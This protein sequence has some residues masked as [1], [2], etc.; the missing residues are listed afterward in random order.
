MTRVL[1]LANVRLPTEKA[2]GLQIMQNCEAFAECGAD[3]TLWAARRVNTPELRGR[4]PFAHYGVERRFRLRRLP[5]LDLLPFVPGQTG[6]LAKVCFAVQMLTYIVSAW[7]GLLFARADVLYSRDAY[8]LLITAPLARL[9]RMRIG[10]EAHTRAGSRFG[11]WA[12]ARAARG[13]QVFTTTARLGE[14]IAALGVEPARIHTAHD[15]IRAARFA[16][17]PDQAAA[18]VA[19]GWPADAFIVG[20]VGRLQ[21]MAMDKGVGLLIE[22][23][24][25][26]PGAMLAL[27]GGPEA[28]AEE[29]RG[30]W[31]ALGLE[32]ARFLYAGQVAPAR[33][34]LLLAAF[35]VCAMPLPWT[36]HFAYYA[37]AIKLFEYMAA[38]RA[39]VA[40]DLPSTREVVADGESALL[41]PPGDAPALAAAI[42]RLKADSALRERLGA[43][44]QTLVMERFTWRARA[45]A[46]LAALTG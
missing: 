6:T 30:R 40:S 45:E 5:T 21:T 11:R 46:I 27:V 26:V 15:G 38:G 9:K 19:L 31:A 41:F 20:Y 22:A 3:V 8:V 34:P 1:Y 2:H 13:A 32:P 42:R 33:V 28:Q 25:S 36:E 39:L 16:D 14:D 7:A 35:D 24:A 18:R 10:Y 37:S 23:L 43:A 12:Q 44:G 17:M 29:Y 4:D